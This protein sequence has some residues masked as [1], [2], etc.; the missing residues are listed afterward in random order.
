MGSQSTSQFLDF[1]Q[2]AFIFVSLGSFSNRKPTEGSVGKIIFSLWGRIKITNLYDMGEIFFAPIIAFLICMGKV[3]IPEVRDNYI[4]YT[5]LLKD[6]KSISQSIIDISRHKL[7]NPHFLINDSTDVKH[8][9][10]KDEIVFISEVK[11]KNYK[12]FLF[13]LKC[14]SFCYTPFFRYDSDGSTHRNYDEAI[15]LKEQQVTTPHFHY[16][17][18]SG[19][20]IAYKTKQL[21]NAKS[22]EALEDINLCVAHFCSEANMRLNKDEFPAISILSKTLQLPLYDEDPNS[23]VNFI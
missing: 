12:Y 3:I 18:N 5:S 6:K 20:S 19:I 1:G 7:S 8:P 15:P 2:L 17:N 13:K 10:I 14:I 4:L 22:K 21:I 16:F 11:V 23:G 9:N